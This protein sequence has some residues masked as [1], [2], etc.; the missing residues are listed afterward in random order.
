MKPYLS[1]I[2]EA[3]DSPNSLPLA[4]IDLDGY[5][6]KLELSYEVIILGKS[7]K[8][9]YIAKKFAKLLKRA[10]F[11]VVDPDPSKISHLDVNGSYGLLIKNTSIP[12]LE[13]FRNIIG[14]LDN[15][16]KSRTNELVFGYHNGDRIK[17]RLIN[18]LG[19]IIKSPIKLNA[20]HLVVGFNKNISASVLNIR[21]FQNETFDIELGILSHRLG[22]K[23]KEILLE[24]RKDEPVSISYRNR[25][26]LLAHALRMRLGIAN[27][28]LTILIKNIQ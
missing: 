2:I 22:Y 5:F 17:E 27:K 6:S 11:K 3:N 15:E 13:S 1:V 20:E 21:K 12:T 25:F 4:L 14:A 24:F 23:I 10:S 9:H 7:E 16:D 26:K 8:L 18:L 19:R 28:N